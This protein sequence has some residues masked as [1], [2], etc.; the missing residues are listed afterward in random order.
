MCCSILRILKTS[1]KPNFPSPPLHHTAVEVIFWDVAELDSQ[2]ALK[3]SSILRILSELKNLGVSRAS[4]SHCLR[5]NPLR[6]LMAERVG[7]E[8]TGPCGPPVFKT[9]ALDHSA[10][11]PIN[12]IKMIYKFMTLFP[13]QTCCQSA[14]T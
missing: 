14:A 3:H 6:G 11:S 5:R 1:R 12:C 4:R 2:S 13:G 8:P 9:G 10:T 7:F